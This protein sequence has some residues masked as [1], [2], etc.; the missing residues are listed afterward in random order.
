MHLFVLR[1]PDACNCQISL[2]SVTIG[3]SSFYRRRLFVCHISFL[4]R[5]GIHSGPNC[6]KQVQA[7]ITIGNS[8]SSLLYLKYREDFFCFVLAVSEF[9]LNHSSDSPCKNG[10]NPRVSLLQAMY[11]VHAFFLYLVL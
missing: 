6:N 7:R 10:S 2:A 8:F 3:Q 5:T 4:F 11:V 1:L 9:D